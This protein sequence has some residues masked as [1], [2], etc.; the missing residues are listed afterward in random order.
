MAKTTEP[1]PGTTDI[2]PQEV[3]EWQFVEKQAHEIFTRYGF[4][5]LRT[6]I[7]ERTEVFVR[8]IGDDTDIVTKEMYTFTDRGGRSVTLRP[9]GTAGI[10]RALINSGISQTEEQRVYYI[11]PMFR[12]ERPAA[13]R[14][15]QFHQIGAECVGK[16][17]PECD[18]E[19]ICMLIHYLKTI[20]IEDYELLL[21][22]RGELGEREHISAKL[23]EYFLSTIEV[24]CNDCQ[25]RIHSNVWRILDCKN[26]VCQAPIATAP[27]IL[28]L[29]GESSKKYFD[30]VCDRLKTLGI[31]FTIEP[32]LVRG[33][34]YYTHTVYEVVSKQIGAQNAIAGG[35]RYEMCFP[36]QKQPLHGVGFAAG[37]E[38]L[39][40]V[41]NKQDKKSG[42]NID[43]YLVSLGEIAKKE[44]L[45][46]A[47]ELRQ[48]GFSVLM[49]LESRGI[50]P[51]MRTANK[52]HAKFVLI[53]GE[54]E[55]KNDNIICKDM[56]NSKQFELPL[57]ETVKEMSICLN[58]S[59]S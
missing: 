28:N 33:L 10:L 2:F 48:N 47:A 11:G 19:S 39:L 34:D 13:G 31:S 3:T 32:R 12:G 14:K 58:R 35:G 9:E 29:L 46:L 22:S 6:P 55:L 24:M 8:S 27:A 42:P 17:F 40:L 52:V 7:F 43:L 51:Q 16:I 49:D 57:A 38:R 4:G 18:V 53:R 30:K 15:R 25:R 23:R 1:V 50:K 36:G 45:K 20:G 56:L 5:E 41:L 54:N 21:N 37:I 26:E 44:N 59:K